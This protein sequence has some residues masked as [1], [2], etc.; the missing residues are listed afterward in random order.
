MCL[1]VCVMQKDVAVEVNAEMATILQSSRFFPDFQIQMLDKQ[2]S[3]SES[4]SQVDD[5]LGLQW[6]NDLWLWMYP[7]V[8]YCLPTFACTNPSKWSLFKMI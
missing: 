4:P 6:Q 2:E 3:S 7:Q 1:F 8:L 5:I